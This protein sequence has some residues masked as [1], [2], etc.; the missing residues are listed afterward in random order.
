MKYFSLLIIIVVAFSSSASFAQ[1]SGLYFEQLD[2]S[3]M[4]GVDLEVNFTAEQRLRCED[5]NGVIDDI[6]F[7][8]TSEYSAQGNIYYKAVIFGASGDDFYVES[9][10][11]EG[12][13]GATKDY[14]FNFP[15][16][17]VQNTMNLCDTNTD[18]F[19]GVKKYSGGYVAGKVWGTLSNTA[20][21][22]EWYGVNNAGY[23]EDLYFIINPGNLVAPISFTQSD[24][25]EM[26]GM[27]LTI[28]DYA[29]QRLSCDD[30]EGIVK[31]IQFQISTSYHKR[32][33]I[34][35][36]AM[37]R[38]LT[39]D[40]FLATSN[41]VT[42]VRNTNQTYTF[43]FGSI[44]LTNT[45]GICDTS[46]EF[47][48]GV[49]MQSGGYITGKVWGTVNHSAYRDTWFRANNAGHLNDLHF[50]FTP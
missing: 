1:A 40:T 44:D 23:L 14:V 32:G 20:Y 13:I 45:P 26:S 16:V 18:F 19:I 3:Q 8:I 49:K 21:R 37:I 36:Q 7:K 22:D 28:V 27:D 46:N 6:V 10:A 15:S 30:F 9:N 48:I 47:M 42:G 50:T 29:N 38:G 17:D 43:D 11:L 39:Y 25:S 33:A 12:E 4:A 35:Y 31:K 24:N 2:S 41:I 5:F 34:T